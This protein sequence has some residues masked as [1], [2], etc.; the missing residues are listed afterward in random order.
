[1]ALKDK[2]GKMN[3]RK[4][5]VIKDIDI[6]FGRL[7]VILLKIIIASIPATFLA[8]V[9]VVVLSVF[10]GSFLHQFMRIFHGAW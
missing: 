6:P 2:E 3:E 9:M 5:I 10:F 7:V 4:E 8:W 1:M